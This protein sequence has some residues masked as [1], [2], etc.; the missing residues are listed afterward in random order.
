[1]SAKKISIAIGILQDMYGDMR[2]LE[3]AAE[4]GADAVDFDTSGGRWNCC[5]QNSIFSK[6]D[7]EIVAYCKALKKRADELGLIIGQTHGRITAF[8]GETEWDTA[9]VK[10]A[11]LDCLV[12]KT[13]GAPVCVMH[14]VSPVHLSVDADPQ[15][16]RDMNYKWFTSVLPFAKQYGIKIATETFGAVGLDCCDFFG[17]IE[18]FIKTYNHICSAEDFANY[19]VTCADTGHSNMASRF[20]NNPSSGDVIRMLGGTLK[21]LHLN[22]NDTFTDQ[23]KPPLTGTLDWND[24]FDALDEIGYDG[25]YNMEL[26]LTWFGPELVVETAAFA[27]KVLRNMLNKRKK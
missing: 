12:A 8:K 7:E 13:L 26:E 23:H 1:M 24:I 20:N 9:V 4:I 25:I 21:A 3:I 15:L 17:N 16:V 27:I 14:G 2:A 18:E 19:F 22:D 5:N 6:S 11:R 10:N